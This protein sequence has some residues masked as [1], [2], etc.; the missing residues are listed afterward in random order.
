MLGV[1]VRCLGGRGQHEPGWCI[2]KGHQLTQQLHHTMAARHQGSR[3]RM[4]MWFRKGFG[5]ERPAGEWRAGAWLEAKY[6]RH[7]T[8]QQATKGP[9]WYLKVCSVLCTDR[10]AV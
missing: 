3:I 7:A 1:T 2:C 8:D 5:G 10:C 9:G 4:G 6:V